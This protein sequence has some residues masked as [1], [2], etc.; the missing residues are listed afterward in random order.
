MAIVKCKQLIALS[1]ILYMGSEF[2]EAKESLEKAL[3][4]CQDRN[5][6][7]YETLPEFS[8]LEKEISG[9]MLNARER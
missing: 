6:L 8:K 7:S 4:L 5:N 3:V 1:T 9:T 2:A